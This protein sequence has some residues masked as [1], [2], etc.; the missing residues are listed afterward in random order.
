MIKAFVF[1]LDD[2]LYPE[3]E[4][5]K[6]G[7]KAIAED[8][9]D[10]N[11]YDKLISLFNEDKADVYQRAGFNDKQCK[12]CIE[13]YRKHMPDIHLSED[14]KDT[15]KTLK[16]RGYKL[17]IITDGRPEGQ[18]NKIK[19]LGL[20]NIMDYIIVTDELGS[21][22]YRKPNPKA[23]ELMKDKLGVEFN[24]MCYIGDNPQKDFFIKSIYSIKVIQLLKNSFYSKGKYKGNIKPDNIVS[25]L[26]EVIDI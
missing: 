26:K 19:A 4:Y 2:T 3:M 15:L 11:I 13:V 14:V 25:S 9:E 10:R 23:F 17:G 21:T 6:S 24:E 5:V 1:D 22:E 7:F 18:R 8:F 12:R 20:N 16:Q